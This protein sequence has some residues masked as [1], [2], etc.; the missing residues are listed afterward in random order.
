MGATSLTGQDTVTI[1]G[2]NFQTLA[3]GNPF[4]VTFPNELG[5]IKRGKNGNGIFALNEMGGIAE[6]TIRV[7]LGGADDKYLNARIAQWRAD[8][9]NFTTLT[10]I[11]VKR[12]GDGRGNNASKVYNLTGG[13]FTKMVEAMTSAEG[14]TDQSVAVYVMRFLDGEVSN[15]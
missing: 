8:P 6:V 4:A 11:L 12:V 13:I 14:N 10:C 1:D 2:L 5:T 3:D 9:S 7:L 15:Q